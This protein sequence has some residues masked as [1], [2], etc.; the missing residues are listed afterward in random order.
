MKTAINGVSLS[1]K[2][3]N[4]GQVSSTEV[5]SGVIVVATKDGKSI[6]SDPIDFLLYVADK[7]ALKA[8]IDRVL[9]EDA[10]ANLNYIDTSEVTDMSLL[11]VSKT[12]FNGDISKWDISSVKNMNSMF[13]GA[14][15]FDQPLNSWNTSKVTKMTGMF[16]RAKAFNQ[17]LNS[18]KVSS[19]IDMH[20][21]FL[22][23][24]KF[25]QDLSAW[26]DNSERKTRDMFSGARAMETLNKPS[27]CSGGHCR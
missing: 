16:V 20:F 26:A 21:M 22:G 4:T 18:W 15:A 23:A 25:N 8:E 27:W 24:T 9:A 10:T 6:D 14:T 19:V 1:D 12:T 17:S 2:D 11:F 13:D 5:V 7:V 3:E